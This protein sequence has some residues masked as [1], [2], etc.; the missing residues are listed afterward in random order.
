MVSEEKEHCCSSKMVETSIAFSFIALSK[1]GFVT[2]LKYDMCQV[3][4]IYLFFFCLPHFTFC[5]L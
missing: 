3:K 5:F 4:Y 1:A 2:S